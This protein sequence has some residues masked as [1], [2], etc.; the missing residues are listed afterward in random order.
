MRNVQSMNTGTP[1]SIVK[2]SNYKKNLCKIGN[3]HDGIGFTTSVQTCKVM[4][5]H[6]QVLGDEFFDSNRNL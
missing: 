6:Y 2:T 1:H 5:N 3:Y 4:I